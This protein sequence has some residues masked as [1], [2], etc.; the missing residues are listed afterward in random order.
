LAMCSSNSRCNSRRSSSNHGR[1]G[2]GQVVQPQL[3]KP[4][5]HNPYQPGR[6]S[7]ATGGSSRT[8]AA[9]AVATA[10]G[11][12]RSTCWR[13]ERCLCH[14]QM[15]LPCWL[16]YPL[17]WQCLSCALLQSL[18]RGQQQQHRSGLREHCGSPA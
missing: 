15:C 8:A 16:L 10:P 11:S 5:N 9:A 14:C 18:Q 3:P 1:A 4:L 2:R 6:S 12:S 7:S 17:C 13:Q